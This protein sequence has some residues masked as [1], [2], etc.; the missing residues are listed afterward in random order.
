MSIADPLFVMSILVA[1]ALLRTGKPS[2][3]AIKRST[4][5]PKFEKE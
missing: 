1:V 3:A 4:A 2:V 5:G